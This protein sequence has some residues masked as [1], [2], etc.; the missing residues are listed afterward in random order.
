[1]NLQYRPS[2][3]VSYIFQFSVA[4]LQRDK[5]S[6]RLTCLSFIQP[7]GGPTAAKAARFTL[8]NP[9]PTQPQV[10][11][12][13]NVLEIVLDDH[14]RD[15]VEHKLDV[16]GVSGT[17]EVRIDLLGLLVA[18]EVLKLPLHIDSCLLIGVLTFVVR[19][20]HCQRNAFDLLSQQVL[21]VEEE[22]E[23]RVGEPVVVADGVKQTQALGHAALCGYGER[24][25]NKKEDEATRE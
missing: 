19:E 6:G 18:V 12:Q 4:P 3:T 2:L 7:D 17:G 23:R 20:A 22:D 21:L 16:A 8:P 15:S 11:A 9:H 13:P 1:M 24:K 5:P 10:L 14:V 25:G